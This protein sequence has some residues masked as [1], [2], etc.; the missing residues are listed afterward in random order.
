MD[1]DGTAVDNTTAAYNDANGFPKLLDMMEA[2]FDGTMKRFT[3]MSSSYIL[4]GNMN[5]NDGIETIALMSTL[6]HYMAQYQEQLFSTET[7]TDNTLPTH[8][9]YVFKL[10]KA[11]QETFEQRLQGFTSDQLRWIS[12]QKA[13]PKVSEVLLPFQRFPGLVLHV[14]EMCNGEVIEIF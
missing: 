4:N 3:S 8:S 12:S 1:T 7:T 6:K 2:L 14:V 5:G 10:F 9:V 13:D 11:L